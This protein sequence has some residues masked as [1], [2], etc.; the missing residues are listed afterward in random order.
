[1]ISDVTEPD[2][3]LAF[4]YSIISNL[5][6]YTLVSHSSLIHTYYKTTRSENRF[7]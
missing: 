1:M 2:L 4:K 5:Q 6:K 3:Q 7:K